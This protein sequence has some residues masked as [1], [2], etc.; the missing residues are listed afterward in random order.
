MSQDSWFFP[1]GKT[2]K[3]YSRKVP[4]E[5][6]LRKIKSI[7]APCK[8][9]WLLQECMVENVDVPHLD[10]TSKIRPWRCESHFY[11]FPPSYNQ[12]RI[13]YEEIISG[14]RRLRI[15]G[16][17]RRF[18]MESD[19][20]RRS[21]NGTLE[22]HYIVHTRE[23]YELLVCQ[24]G[25]HRGPGFTEMVQAWSKALLQIFD[26]YGLQVIYVTTKR[27]LLVTFAIPLVYRGKARENV[28]IM[29]E[30]IVVLCRY[31]AQCAPLKPI[32]TG[33]LCNLHRSLTQLDAD[34]SKMVIRGMAPYSMFSVTWNHSFL[35]TGSIRKAEFHALLQSA[36]L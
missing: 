3:I 26:M 16:S 8:R 19:I 28:L 31:C 27:E 21:I 20:F 10:L 17:Y 35:L 24:V 36:H 1:A 14:E 18:W 7:G 4:F 13:F 12:D 34:T 29:T 5:K 23:R 2:G 15:P 9:D 32:N 6:L 33:K 22:P 25:D 11:L 30:N